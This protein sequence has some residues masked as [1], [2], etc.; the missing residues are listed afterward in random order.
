LC[1]LVAAGTFIAF[2]RRSFS[3]AAATAGV[4]VNHHAIEERV[5]AA[6]GLDSTLAGAPR[7][8]SALV[9]FEDYQCV[10]DAGENIHHWA[11]PF[12]VRPDPRVVAYVRN[13]ADGRLADIQFGGVT[14]RFPDGFTA[15]LVGV[16]HTDPDARLDHGTDLIEA[17][18][19]LPVPNP[20]DTTA[21]LATPPKLARLTAEAHAALA[22]AQRSPSF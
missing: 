16:V 2:W 14:E 10:I 13:L 22:Q 9:R 21:P 7:L 18:G 11:R 20:H 19:W 4:S 8:W 5:L 17:L 1:G 3:T 12:A 15:F 6:H